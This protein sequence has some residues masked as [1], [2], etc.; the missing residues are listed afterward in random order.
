[1]PLKATPN[2]FFSNFLQ[3]VITR[4]RTGEFVGWNRHQ[5]LL[6]NVITIATI[7]IVAMV[8]T[9]SNG[10]HKNHCRPTVLSKSSSQLFVEARSIQ[11][12]MAGG[13]HVEIRCTLVQISVFQPCFCCCCCCSCYHY[14]SCPLKTLQQPTN[15]AVQTEA[16]LWAHPTFEEPYRRPRA[17]LSNVFIYWGASDW[18]LWRRGR[19]VAIATTIIIII[20]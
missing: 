13:T 17:V 12:F 10:I 18:W 7:N 8:V 19:R 3:L 16:F 15:S 6:Q 5:L 1:M 2:S 4:W 14:I 20:K 11:N 9:T